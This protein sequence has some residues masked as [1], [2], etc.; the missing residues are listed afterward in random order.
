[1]CTNVYR[2]HTTLFTYATHHQK[3][4]KSS[5]TNW[6]ISSISCRHVLVL[7]VLRSTSAATW[8]ISC[9]TYADALNYLEFCI[10]RFFLCYFVRHLG[11]CNQICVKLLQLMCAV[12]T[13][14]LVKNEVSILIN[15]WVTANYSVSCRNFIRHLAIC[16]PICIKLL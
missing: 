16:N 1:M 13:H 9:N 8:R 15:G 12:I 6:R 11:I 10:A 5:A 14:N 7:I 2:T 3:V 4:A